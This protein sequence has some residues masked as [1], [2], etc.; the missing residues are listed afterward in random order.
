MLAAC[1]RIQSPGQEM[2]LRDCVGSRRRGAGTTA[3]ANGPFKVDSQA[4]SASIVTQGQFQGGW[5]LLKMHP[6]CARPGPGA[7]RGWRGSGGPWPPR[8]AQ[9]GQGDLAPNSSAAS[10]PVWGWLVCHD[11]WYGKTGGG[12]YQAY[13]G[14]YPRGYMPWYIPR[15]SYGARQL[16][17]PPSP[18]VATGGI[19]R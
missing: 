13:A 10:W 9:R 6:G 15:R 17:S 3:R 5:R 14:I 7:W 12:I 8:A 2:E 18:G 1:Q 16:H 11:A 4:P 19:C